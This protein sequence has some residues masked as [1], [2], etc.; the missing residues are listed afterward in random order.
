MELKIQILQNFSEKFQNGISNISFNF[1]ESHSEVKICSIS[2]LE[3][4]FSRKFN[5][6]K[7]EFTANE[8]PSN[9]LILNGNLSRN[10]IIKMQAVRE[11]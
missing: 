6:L 8:A 4:F 7:N 9:K 5:I 1:T 11:L 3:D 2:T 10:D